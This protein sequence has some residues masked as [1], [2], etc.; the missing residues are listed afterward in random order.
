[1]D[2]ENPTVSKALGLSDSEYDEMLDFINEVGI[3]HN[4]LSRK[5]E[6]IIEKY[7]PDMVKVIFGGFLLGFGSHDKDD[8]EWKK[9]LK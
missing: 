9:Y 5:M 1:M 6:M 2:H 8:E 7:S 3:S 4:H